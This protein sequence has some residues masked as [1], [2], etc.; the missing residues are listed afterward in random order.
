VS[1][2][3]ILFNAAKIEIFCEKTMKL[4]IYN[5]FCHAKVN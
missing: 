2:H 4:Y 3:L 1:Y 5:H